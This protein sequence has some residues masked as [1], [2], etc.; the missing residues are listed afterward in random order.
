M[1]EPSMMILKK[2]QQQKHSIH[3]KVALSMTIKDMHWLAYSPL[4]PLYISVL[5]QPGGLVRQ[6]TMGRLNLKELRREKLFTGQP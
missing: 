4:K 5:L 2:Q 3:A 6:V 1:M